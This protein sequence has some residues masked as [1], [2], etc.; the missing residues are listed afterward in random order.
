M[1]SI[2]DR[3]A[4]ADRRTG[5]DE[6]ARDLVRAIGEGQIEVLFQPQFACADDSLAGAEALARWNHPRAGRVGAEAMFAIAGRA[7]MAE[8]LTRHV[9]ARALAEA[10]RWPGALRLSL[11]ITAAD[12]GADDFAESIA[13]LVADAGFSAE[14]LTLEITEQALVRDV[15]RS[16]AQLAQLAGRG[17]R[18]ALDDFGAGFCNF[19]YLKILPLDY[20]KL[21]RTMIEGIVSCERDLAV[22]RA[23]VAMAGAL[24]LAVIAE[25]IETE[26][27]LEKVRAE[28]CAL[29]QGFLRARPMEADAFLNHI[30]DLS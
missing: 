30:R 18:I 23:I 7:G 6:L 12:L 21:D 16:A 24:D 10:A 15:E 2:H 1:T 9:A 28:H 22:L 4:S 25:G 3:R 17:I 27:Q 20:L 5:D 11:N 13:A 29:Y 14:R 8:A 19:R 26:E